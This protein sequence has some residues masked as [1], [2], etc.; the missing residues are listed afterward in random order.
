MIPLSDVPK[1][2]LPQIEEF[3]DTFYYPA[4]AQAIVKGLPRT[5]GPD[6]ERIHLEIL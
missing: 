6:A 4:K 2:A 3:M 1:E 5:D